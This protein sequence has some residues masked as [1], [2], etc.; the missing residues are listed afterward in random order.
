MQPRDDSR[1]ANITYESFPPGSLMRCFDEARDAEEIA[2]LKGSS[3]KLEE[4]DERAG[5]A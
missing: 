3:L 1:S 2:L 4:G 5:D